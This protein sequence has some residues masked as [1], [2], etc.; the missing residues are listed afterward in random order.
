[1]TRFWPLTILMLVSAI[2]VALGPSFSYA[3]SCGAIRSQLLSAGRSGGTSPE[4]A[5]LRRQLAAIQKLERQR[6][7]TART[8]GFFF[9]PCADLVSSKAE[10]QRQIARLSNSSRDTSGLKAR[11][12]AL[13][14][15]A[16]AAKKQPA[17]QRTAPKA[18]SAGTTIGGNRMLFC[19]RL[20]DGYFFPAPKSQFAKGDDLK[21]TV[22]QCRYICDDAGVDLYTL[23]D[24][25][26]ETEEMVALESGKPYVELPAAFRYRDDANFKACDVKR[27]YRRVAELR[28]R[29]VTPANMTNAIIPL[30]T[31]KPDF[32]I[33]AEIP[34]S[35][36]ETAGAVPQE[37]KTQAAEVQGV[38]QHQSIERAIGA[39]PV[40]VVGPAFFPAD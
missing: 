28:A 4:L 20:S 32:G 8:A 34:E 33:V 9:N 7:C 12:V 14:C 22:D 23:S 30:P 18:Q 25:T 1:M 21:E 27:Y 6:R 10:V 3:D 24:A 35:G 11:F 26:R 17:Q 13:G 15:A 39:R 19:V 31:A 2:A 5:Q 29:T 36:I 40:R 37:A 16:P 38:A